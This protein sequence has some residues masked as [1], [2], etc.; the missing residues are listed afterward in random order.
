LKTA[1]N[2]AKSYKFQPWTLILGVLQG[3]ITGFKLY[4]EKKVFCLK[5]NAIF[6]V[7]K[8]NFGS[9]FGAW[10]SF[11]TAILQS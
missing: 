6:K 10:V 5:L 3:M 11:H 9:K 2:I 7:V 1:R 4:Q 8:M